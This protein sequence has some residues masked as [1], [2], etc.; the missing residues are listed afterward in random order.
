MGHNYKH[1]KHLMLILRLAREGG[2][3][4]LEIPCSIQLSYRRN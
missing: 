3:A 1:N 4:E 2:L